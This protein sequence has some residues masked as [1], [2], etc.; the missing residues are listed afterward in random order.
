MTSV[1]HIPDFSTL[2]VHLQWSGRQLREAA[3]EQQDPARAEA[4]RRAARRCSLALVLPLQVL[5]ILAMGNLA[6]RLDGDQEGISPI[7]RACT[8]PI[9]FSPRGRFT[10]H[11]PALDL[12]S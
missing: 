1:L 9:A 10:S 4:Q 7:A 6:V 8:I 12:L 11:L 3:L 5:R 2:S